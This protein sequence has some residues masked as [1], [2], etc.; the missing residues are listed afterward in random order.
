MLEFLDAKYLKICVK[1]FKIGRYFF[2]LKLSNVLKERFIIP[3][4]C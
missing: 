1:S 3:Y 4:L 2:N